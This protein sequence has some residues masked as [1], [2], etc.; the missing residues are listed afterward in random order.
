VDAFEK[1]SSL[2][3]RAGRLWGVEIWLHWTLLVAAA[4]AF[5]YLRE[6]PQHAA[7]LVVVLLCSV[8]AHELGHCW[9]ARRVGGEA[10][11]VVLWPLGGLA[12]LQTPHTPAAQLVST[13]AGPLVNVAIALLALPP[14]LA[15]GGGWSFSSMS[16]SGG[17]LLL[18]MVMGV[19]V[20]L[21]FFNLIPAYPMDG[22]RIL[23][24]ALWPRVGLERATA[25]AITAALVVA[26]MLGAWAAAT[27]QWLL[28]GIMVMIAMA[29]LAERARATASR[30]LVWPETPDPDAPP[31]R[32]GRFAAW[33]ER[34]RLRR[35]EEESRACAEMRARLDDVLAKVTERG[36]DGLT[37]EERR[38]LDQASQM[39]RR[40]QESGKR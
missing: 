28:L 40:E 24:A 21:A 26:G 17:P 4:W 18:G 11:E 14:F 25:I 38:F 9:G 29:A 8:L 5:Y 32:Q 27:G 36:L 6:S 37:R 3:V 22:G 1:L 10:R 39:L 19:N 7:M 15:L 33:R 30:E 31:P 12:H 20:T 23:Q 34:R 35:E 13:A 16:P 2:R